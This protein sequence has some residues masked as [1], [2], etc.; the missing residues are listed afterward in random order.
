MGP[1]SQPVKLYAVTSTRTPYNYS[2]TVLAGDSRFWC[3][4]SNV[5][6]AESDFASG[7]TIYY[8]TTKTFVEVAFWTLACNT[9]L[10]GSLL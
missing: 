8:L 9:T 6:F 1:L 5:L 7:K 4:R 3:S 10:N 2:D